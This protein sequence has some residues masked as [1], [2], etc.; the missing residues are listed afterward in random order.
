[1]NLPLS[2]GFTEPHRFWVVLFSFSFVSMHIFISALISSVMLVIQKCVVYPP[3]VCIVIVF[4]S[5]CWHL[6]LP[7]CDDLFWIK[8]CIYCVCGIFI[9]LHVTIQFYWGF[10]GGLVVRNPP[11]NAGDARHVG[12]IPGSAGSPGEGNGN[13][14]QYSCL[15]NPMDRGAWWATVH[16]LP[17]YLISQLSWVSSLLT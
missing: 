17:R 2:T 12:L 10:L 16:R 1:M 3:Y 5:S 15:E 6:I 14:L 7:H 13:P 8:I 4:F 9:L 11:A